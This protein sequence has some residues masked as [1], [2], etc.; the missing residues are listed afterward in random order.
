MSPALARMAAL[1]RDHPDAYL[2]INTSML[3]SHVPGEDGTP[4]HGNTAVAHAAVTGALELRNEELLQDVL[5]HMPSNVDI[6]PLVMQSIRKYQWGVYELIRASGESPS[7]E[8]L[9]EAIDVDGAV[10]RFAAP[11]DDRDLV[12]R[13]AVT[14]G[15]ALRHATDRL[16]DDDEVVLRVVTSERAYMDAFE[17]AS[18]RLRSSADF[19]RKALAAGARGVLDH[20]LCV[21]DKDLILDVIRLD[22]LLFAKVPRDLKEDIEV[23][24]VAVSGAPIN[25]SHLSRAVC[26]HPTVAMA[27]VQAN[28]IY[29]RKLN[30][31][32]RDTYDIVHAAVSNAGMRALCFASS[33][34]RTSLLLRL[35]ACDP[36]VLHDVDALTS[37]EKEQ[38]SDEIAVYAGKML[39]RYEKAERIVSKIH[40]P[41][42][43]AFHGLKRSYA[44]AFEKEGA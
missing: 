1:V 22:P 28:G 37:E 34:L 9:Q 31:E 15:D 2:M 43:E 4:V 3:R 35:L 32:N 24:A 8:V 40:A 25:W 18:E 6:V 11:C 26:N 29:L 12:M 10:L 16:R 27:L 30:P 13:A 17:F 36:D 21:D 14:Y 19:V 42:G 44:A 41:D 38:Y 23:A 20:A 33:R 39:E 5:H 7:A